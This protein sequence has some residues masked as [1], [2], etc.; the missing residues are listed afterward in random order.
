LVSSSG[1]AGLAVRIASRAA[2]LVDDCRCCSRRNQN[3]VSNR[4]P[5]AVGKDGL[6]VDVVFVWRRFEDE[7]S[8]GNGASTRRVAGR[9]ASPHEL[10]GLAHLL[11][12]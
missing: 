6:S 4:L 5:H 1:G 3:Y 9:L 8:P 2:D 12:T 7:E 11:V 10:V